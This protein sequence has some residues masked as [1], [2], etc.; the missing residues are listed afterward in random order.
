M[1][2]KENI[3]GL[4]K[5]HDDAA[6]E[7]DIAKKQSDAKPAAENLDM[8]PNSVNKQGNSDF[9]ANQ[10]NDELHDKA[11]AYAEKEHAKAKNWDENTDLTDNKT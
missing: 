9:E 7:N 11:S 1:D 6:R 2:I 4:G 3:A 10:K 5:D 8:M